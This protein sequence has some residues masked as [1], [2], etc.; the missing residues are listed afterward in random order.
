MI[1]RIL[2][3]LTLVLFLAAPAFAQYQDEDVRVSATQIKGDALKPHFSGVTHLGTYSVTR[4]N[5]GV[6]HYTETTQADGTVLYK[7]GPLTA[8]GKWA[9][10]GDRICYTYE[11]EG[12]NGG[13]FYV[14]KMGNCFF[15]YNNNEP[16]RPSRTNVYWVAKSVKKGEISSCDPAIG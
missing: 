7:E 6:K 14:Y 8:K 11:T 2:S 5:T 9:Q 4:Q 12:M 16:G 3:A 10:F 1:I 13:C 15:Y